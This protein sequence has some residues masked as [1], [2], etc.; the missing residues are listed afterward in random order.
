VN[1]VVWALA[2]LG[3]VA[4][5]ALLIAAIFASSRVTLKRRGLLTTL[6]VTYAGYFI[7]FFW[8]HGVMYL[9]HYFIP[10]FLTFVLC[11][12]VLDELPGPPA[13]Q[14]QLAVVAAALVV[15]GFWFYKPLSY[16]EPLTDRQ[17]QR[18]AV[19]SLWDL[20][21]ATCQRDACR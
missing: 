9:Y 2:L 13:R 4:A 14:R 7:P 12:L 8:I 15:A 6:V 18:R 20:R 11:A 3:L 10:L 19:V 17:L 21:C 16:Y 1:P 5:V